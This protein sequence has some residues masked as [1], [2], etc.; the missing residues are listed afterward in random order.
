RDGEV[1]GVGATQPPGGPHAEIEALRGAGE[2]A[3]GATAY[4]TLEPCPH[5]GRTPPCADALIDA[6]VA[7]VV[8]AIQDPDPHARGE[9][10]ERLR[11][12]G[13]N[14]DVGVE[15]DAAARLLAPYLAHRDLERPFVVLKT[16]TSLDGR[17]A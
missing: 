12:Q 2:R 14:V 11:A 5:Y 16:A 6:G 7:R 1:V 8:V 15:A 17:T 4:V 3:I 10:I 9:G 13:I